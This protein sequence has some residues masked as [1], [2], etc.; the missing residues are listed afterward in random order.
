MS[1]EVCQIEIQLMVLIDLEEL[2]RTIRT[3]VRRLNGVPETIAKYYC[4]YR[5]MQ[6]CARH[7]G[8][9]RFPSQIDYRY[10]H[11]N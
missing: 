2:A 1:E 6:N 7:V 11:Q 8:L 9:D 3:C 4:G 10:P 5:L